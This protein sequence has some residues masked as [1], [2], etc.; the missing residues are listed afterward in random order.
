[1]NNRVNTIGLFGSTQIQHIGKVL[2]STYK[3]KLF[4]HEHASKLRKIFNWIHFILLIDCLYVVY[5][6]TNKKFF[7][8]LLL[9]K[10][11]RKKLILHWIGT[12]VLEI[13]NCTGIKG[14]IL[15][16]FYNC[17]DCKFVCFEGL[18]EELLEKKIYTEVL[19]IVP[20]EMDLSI[21]SQP[22]EHVVLIYMPKGREKFYGYDILKNIF[23]K[24]T[25]LKFFIVAND[26][27]SLFDMYSNVH[28]LGVLSLQEMTKLYSR[29]SIILRYTKHD[30]LSMSVLEG[31]VKGK[32]VIWNHKF[33][34][35]HYV[36]SEEKIVDVLKNITNKK[37]IVNKLNSE[38]IKKEFTKKK[39]MEKFQESINE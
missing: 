5:V 3:V 16:K 31:L 11:F 9:A 20:F 10:I 19:P 35:V 26:N 29:V 13:Y 14:I 6:S 24:F 12:D 32:E 1:M 18:R 8:Q 33:P 27:R 22:E 7:C 36:D 37:P 34:C 38:R 2:A 15:R 30:G 21:T 25:M 28:V 4:R 39:F 17:A 23:A